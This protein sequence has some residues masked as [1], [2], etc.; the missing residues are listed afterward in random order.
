MPTNQTKQRAVAQNVVQDVDQT[1]IPSKAL[2]GSSPNLSSRHGPL[3]TE[4]SLKQNQ[5]QPH[6]KH[7]YSST[8]RFTHSRHYNKHRRSSIAVLHSPRNDF[9]HDH[10]CITNGHPASKNSPQSASCYEHIHQ[11]DSSYGRRRYYNAHKHTWNL[12][13]R[14]LYSADVASRKSHP[15]KPERK[16]QKIDAQS[17]G[18]QALGNM[19]TNMISQRED[20]SVLLN[21]PEAPSSLIKMAML[22]DPV[23]GCFSSKEV[24]KE[25]NSLIS[26]TLC[27]LNEKLPTIN[28]CEQAGISREN[29]VSVS[30]SNST[31]PSPIVVGNEEVSCALAESS[32]REALSDSSNEVET[33]KKQVDLTFEMMMWKKIEAQDQVE[34][35]T[36]SHWISCSTEV[37][38]SIPSAE[39]S[40][41]HQELSTEVELTKMTTRSS[42]TVN[43]HGESQLLMEDQCN[44]SVVTSRRDI[45]VAM[46][47]DG[48]VAA[49]MSHEDFIDHEIELKVKVN[50]TKELV[51]SDF[52]TSF[53]AATCD[54]PEGATNQQQRIAPK[55]LNGEWTKCE[56]ASSSGER[57]H[58][59]KGD[60]GAFGG[61]LKQAASD[62]NN[63]NPSHVL[64]EAAEGESISDK[65]VKNQDH[66]ESKVPQNATSKKLCIPARES[67]VKES[68]EKAS[69]AEEHSIEIDTNDS[70]LAASGSC[71]SET[72]QNQKENESKSLS[73]SRFL[74]LPNEKD[75][76]YDL[77]PRMNHNL[78]VPRTQARP[79]GQHFNHWISN[80]IQLI[81]RVLCFEH[82]H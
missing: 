10:V 32:N 20:T 76:T 3:S 59:I 65:L 41:L 13:K 23:E 50:E 18:Q 52:M 81:G 28:F 63:T 67:D 71:S 17:N 58:A 14:S 43:L 48:Y 34:P 79:A 39:H 80:F 12:N 57:Q 51:N 7:L 26:Q 46:T 56:L 72:Y 33:S 73:G 54:L 36:I 68:K 37:D 24:T 78:G 47:T 70:L 44:G 42:P 8:V 45:A 61:P 53:C 15:Q 77:R 2:P 64:N 25:A 1:M 49:N 62:N 75:K 30:N 69:H 82:I 31:S 38:R 6:Q 55:I 40:P 16:H 21:A 5:Q 11:I 29:D 22:A 19:T 74:D 66:L 9:D 35:S 60:S 4:R 27:E